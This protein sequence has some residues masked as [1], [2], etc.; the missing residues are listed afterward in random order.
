M[1]HLAISE[2]NVLRLR[3]S[4]VKWT[5]RGYSRSVAVDPELK[6]LVQKAQGVAIPDQ[7]MHALP[8]RRFPLQIGDDATQFWRHGNA[9]AAT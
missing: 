2:Q 3:Q 8:A 6:S 7:G 5:F 9:D 4:K 1:L